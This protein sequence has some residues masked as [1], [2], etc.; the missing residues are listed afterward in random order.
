M[1]KENIIRYCAVAKINT[2]LILIPNVLQSICFL[3]LL[4]M[5]SGINDLNQVETAKLLERYVMLI[6]IIIITPILR[7]EQQKEIKEVVRS[8]YTSHIGITGIRILMAV[9]TVIFLTIIFLMILKQNHCIFPLSDFILGGV[10]SA[11]F[12]GSLGLVAA[13]V[14]D[15]IVLGYMLSVGYYVFNLFTGNKYVGNFY[16]FS[17]SQGS[18]EEKYY[19]LYGALIMFLIV[20]VLQWGER[21]VK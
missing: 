21:K 2:R 8:K 7:A 11:M 15:Q 9:V 13:V 3:L 20:L 6:G 14:A 10:S 12:L 5:M 4:A 18:M 16:L 17:M 19:L 1:F